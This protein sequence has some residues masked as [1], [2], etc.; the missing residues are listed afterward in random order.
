MAQNDLPTGLGIVGS[1]DG[2]ANSWSQSP[3]RTASARQARPGRAGS[4][5]VDD[6]IRPVG[7]PLIQVEA[8]TGRSGKSDSISMA[9][10]KSRLFLDQNTAAFG[11]SPDSLPQTPPRAVALAALSGFVER[12]R[13]IVP[14][15]AAPDPAAS[16]YPRSPSLLRPHP[17]LRH[18]SGSS[19]GSSPRKTWRQS[20]AAV[21]ALVTVAY[22][23]SQHSRV[24]R[25]A[26]AVQ[27]YM[28]SFNL[29]HG[30]VT[31]GDS[32]RT[33]PPLRNHNAA[34]SRSDSAADKAEV[35]KPAHQHPVEGHDGDADLPFIATAASGDSS[36]P[37]TEDEQAGLAAI[38]EQAETA[39]DTSALETDTGDDS[40]ELAEAAVGTS[41][42][43]QVAQEDAPA[44]MV[45][46]GKM[47]GSRNEA[48][49]DETDEAEA[50]AQQAIDRAKNSARKRKAKKKQ[51][52]LSQYKRL[53]PLGATPRRYLFGANFV[54]ADDDENAHV[55][56]DTERTNGMIKL[57]SEKQLAQVFADGRKKYLDEESSWRSF[58]W[59]APPPH[60]SLQR[61]LDKLSPVRAADRGYVRR[62]NADLASECRRRSR[63][64]IGSSLCTSSRSREALVSLPAPPGPQPKDSE[65]CRPLIAANGRNGPNSPRKP[66]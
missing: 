12:V 27:A 23:A 33:A 52:D 10:G 14:L 60:S 20:A 15:G 34:P 35:A 18:A 46:V 21:V 49:V 9:R 17:T 53:L 6:A 50:K 3:E 11:R 22:L 29:V 43:E 28:A 25:S 26:H 55:I 37:S 63:F 41:A 56:S 64:E 42:R 48:T 1:G 57:L 51:K 45:K 54:I 2:D 61:F 36:E 7:P 58:E 16:Q 4:A 62:P 24:H 13:A 30:N 39:D 8:A 47:D 31:F 66:S 32:L 19:L 65:P 59:Q 38:V 44:V 5:L 40:A